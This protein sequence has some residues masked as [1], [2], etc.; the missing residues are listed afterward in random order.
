MYFERTL[1]VLLLQISLKSGGFLSVNCGVLFSSILHNINYAK[2]VML[3]VHNLLSKFLKKFE[4]TKRA[5]STKFA[6]FATAT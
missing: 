5:I 3:I 6:T 1:S 4:P 2:L